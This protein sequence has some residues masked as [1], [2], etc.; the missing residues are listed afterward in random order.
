MAGVVGEF[1][2]PK[3][4]FWVLTLY[5]VSVPPPPPTPLL[6]QWHK[7]TPVTLPKV[8]VTGKPKPA[9]T[10]DPMKSEWANYVVQAKGGN[11]S[12]K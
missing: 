8:Q 9:S 4:I 3:L 5:L 6:L 7:I 2:S 10:S 12:G 11:R 1:S